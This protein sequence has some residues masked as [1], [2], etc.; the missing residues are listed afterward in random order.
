MVLID[1]EPRSVKPIN[2]INLVALTYWMV[3]TSLVWWHSSATAIPNV[4]I[5]SHYLILV[6]YKICGACE[7][8]KITVLLPVPAE[9]KQALGMKSGDIY[10]RQISASSEWDSNHAAIQGRL[11]FLAGSGKQGSWSARHNNLDQW[12]QIDLLDPVTKV[13]A[14]STQGRNAYSQWVTK[15]KLQYSV[16][17]VNF[18][19][20]TEVG[21]KVIFPIIAYHSQRFQGKS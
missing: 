1:T 7:R 17:G 15:Y 5:L 14:V 21:E 19:Y 16:D 9:C 20:Y 13:T 3:Q 6:C 8:N 10:D 11:F 18:Q 4:N 2:L 12:L